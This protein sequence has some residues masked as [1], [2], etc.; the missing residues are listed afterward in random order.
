[1]QIH[2]NEE[3]GIDFDI[4]CHLLAHYTENVFRFRVQQ[5]YHALAHYNA[6]KLFEHFPR[7][8]F[9]RRPNIRIN[10]HQIKHSEFALVD[11]VNKIDF[12]NLSQHEF[13]KQ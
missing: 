5:Y 3:C 1:M 6:R 11:H 8:S 10:K 12:S 13:H 2:H 7:E 9:F 4:G